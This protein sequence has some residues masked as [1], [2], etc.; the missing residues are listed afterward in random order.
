MDDARR[1]TPKLTSRA[2]LH[3]DRHDRRMMLLSP[4]RGLILNDSARAILERCDGTRTTST[5]VD[6]LVTLTGGARETIMRDVGVL[7][8]DLRRRGLLE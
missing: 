7:L 1:D 8:D 4:E 6:E 2:R 3:W 5:I